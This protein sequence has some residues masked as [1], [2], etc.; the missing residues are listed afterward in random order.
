MFTAWP[1]TIS[2]EPG[3]TGREPFEEGRS[4][5]PGQY[6]GL[7]GQEGMGG[8]GGLAT[9]AHDGTIARDTGVR[10][11]EVVG[12]GGPKDVS[13]FITLMLAYADELVWFLFLQPDWFRHCRIWT[14]C[15]TR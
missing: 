2:G 15:W 6:D 13:L 8:A 1:L 3:T 5:E 7:S 12:L 11:G 14:R 4:S 10:D 9:D